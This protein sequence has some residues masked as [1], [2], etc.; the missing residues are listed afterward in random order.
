MKVKLLD[1]EEETLNVSLSHDASREWQVRN[2][3]SVYVMVK[4]I[5][6]R[7]TRNGLSTSIEHFDWSLKKSSSH[8]NNRRLPWVNKHLPFSETNINI[9][10]PKTSP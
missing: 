7:G 1:S 5:V 4:I 8:S 9:L 3:S 10:D 6:S 2:M